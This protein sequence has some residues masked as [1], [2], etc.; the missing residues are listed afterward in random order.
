M[1]PGPG[2]Y[3]YSRSPI[4]GM[5]EA[6]VVAFHPD[7]SYALVLEREADSGQTPEEILGNP[8]TDKQ[9]LLVC[10]ALGIT[11]SNVYA[12]LLASPSLA[13]A[14]ALG[15]RVVMKALPP[16]RKPKNSSKPRSRG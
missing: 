16:V 14:R 13:V 15:V 2:S 11:P 4:G 9:A 8:A 3:L 10:K 5:H 12:N 1:T 6:V 7:G